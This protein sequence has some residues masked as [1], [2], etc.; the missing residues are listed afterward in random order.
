MPQYM[1]RN[2]FVNQRGTNAARGCQV[3]LEQILKS[4]MTP[5][6]PLERGYP[7]RARHR[8]AIIPCAR[9]KIYNAPLESLTYL[10]VA[11]F[12]DRL[13]NGAG[14]RLFIDETVHLVD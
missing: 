8:I 2:V 9:K 1:R 11:I 14:I 5:S 3:F 12:D 13:T 10:L 6:Q 7:Y 4:V